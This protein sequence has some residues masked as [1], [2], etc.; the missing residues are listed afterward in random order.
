M[1][2][3]RGNG[4][5]TLAEGELFEVE[6]QRRE[7]SIRRQKDSAGYPHEKGKKSRVI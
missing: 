1:Q 7:N 2:K 4:I 3:W 5:K 6:S